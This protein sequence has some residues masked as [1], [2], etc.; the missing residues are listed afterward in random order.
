MG[1][2]VDSVMK[3]C[4]KQMSSDNISIILI[5]FK[6]FQKLYDLED[7]EQRAA[8]LKKTRNENIVAYSLKTNINNLETMSHTPSSSTRK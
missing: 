5:A 1:L 3:S 6:N 4:F 8:K 2:I 7:L